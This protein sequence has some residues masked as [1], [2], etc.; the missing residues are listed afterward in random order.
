MGCYMAGDTLM[1]TNKNLTFIEI[2]AFISSTQKISLS[3]DV[4]E[5]IKTSR[6]KFIC[7]I[8]SEA[9]IKLIVS[10]AQPLANTCQREKP[11]KPKIG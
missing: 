1:I 3:D 7:L 5:K 2:T 11:S 9:T 6:G 8:K 10:M 4:K